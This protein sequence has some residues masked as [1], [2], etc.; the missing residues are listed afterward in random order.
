MKT[1]EIP[2]VIMLLAGMIDCIISIMDNLDLLSFCI[3]LLI[4]LLVFYF[5]GVIVRIVVEINFK[6][7]LEKNEQADSNT[8]DDQQL[9]NIDTDNDIKNS[10]EAQGTVVEKNETNS[11]IQ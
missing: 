3:R 11:D 5:F 2:A 7:L 9:E 4:V 1:K 6:N 8:T 10:D